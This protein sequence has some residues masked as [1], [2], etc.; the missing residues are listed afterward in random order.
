MKK[1]FLSLLLVFSMAFCL[2]LPVSA[3]AL[4]RGRGE[5]SYAFL[6]NYLLNYGKIGGGVYTYSGVEKSEE[7]TFDITAVYDP[8]SDQLRFGVSR[9]QW[10]PDL[11]SEITYSAE[12]VVP[13]TLEMPYSAAQTVKVNDFSIQNGAQIGSDF[14]REGDLAVTGNTYDIADIPELFA[15]S[16][17]LALRHTQ[18][19]LFHGSGYTIADLGFTALFEELYGDHTHEATTNNAV[20]ATCTEAGFS[21][22]KFCAVC[23]EP[24]GAGEVVPALGHKPEL[25]NAKPATETETG[26]TGD[27]VCSVCGEIMKKGEVIPKIAPKT[28]DGGSGCP[29]RVFT[30]VNRS[31]DCWYHHAVDWAVT[32]KVTTGLTD[33]TFGPGA[34]CTRAQMVTFLW[35][36]VGE[37]EPKSASN[38]FVDVPAGQYY[39]KAVLWALENGITTGIDAAHFA[40]NNT[41]TRAQTVTFLWRL[42]HEPA[43][44]GSQ[45]FPD[46]PAGQYYAKAVM[47][48]VENNITNGMGNGNFAPGSNCTRAQIVTFLYRAV[49][50]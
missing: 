14:T 40:P 9:K 41:V 20:P 48:A 30:D 17:A 3:S 5:D 24:M 1:R 2:L 16:I 13:S 21:G 47:W 37:P 18:D 12:L 42:K 4:E 46:V 31:A 49:A 36:A 22:D 29:S 32:N 35:R 50:G 23:G 34:S 38:P 44:S 45:S 25:K 11:E 27:E 39:A 10:N 19:H 6:K 15:N 8:D 33:T 43:P 28:C 7:D 26:Y